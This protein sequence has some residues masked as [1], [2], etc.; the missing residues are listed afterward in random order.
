[1]RIDHLTRR[2]GG[3]KKKETQT[4]FTRQHARKQDIERLRGK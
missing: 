3:I 4:E 2:T 1:M